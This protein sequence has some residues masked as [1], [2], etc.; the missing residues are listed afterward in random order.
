[1]KPQ[2]KIIGFACTLLF[3]PTFSHAQG[4]LYKWT[5][6]RGNIHYSN[7][8]TGTNAKAIDDTLPPAASFKS[9]TPPSEAEPTPASSTESGTAPGS[10]GGSATTGEPGSTS[11]P[12]TT[13]EGSQSPP[14]R[15]AT[16][17]EPTS[18]DEETTASQ[19]ATEEK[20][21]LTP[22]Q[23]QALKDSPM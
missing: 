8:P 23:E 19:Q 20:P 7:T 5:D 21:A 3:I 6:S 12:E 2:V 15:E 16:G 17:N 14:P 11:A 10:E 1:M 22:E 13:A 18:D 4:T 9:L